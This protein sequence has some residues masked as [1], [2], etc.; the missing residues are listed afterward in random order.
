MYFFVLALYNPS[1]QFDQILA[2]WEQNDHLGNFQYG[3][4]ICHVTPRTKSGIRD[5]CGQ[6]VDG[7]ADWISCHCQKDHNDH[8][9]D[10]IK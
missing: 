1:G 8:G 7:T 5:G 3:V 2:E 4:N 6:T 10:H 9:P